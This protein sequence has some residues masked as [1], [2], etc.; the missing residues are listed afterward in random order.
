MARIMIV[1]D[2]E[3]NAR[4]I[5]RVLSHMGGHEVSVTEDAEEVLEACTGGCVDLVV[6]DVSLCNT[7]YLGKTVDGLALTRLIR[8]LV[9]APSPP[10]LLLTAHAM[11]GDRERL[12]QASGA[13]GYLAKPIVDHNELVAE[14]ARLVGTATAAIGNG[15]WAM[16]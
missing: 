12:L 13:D 1:E 8:E 14:A 6:M 11:R 10:V 2:D 16:V 4:V 9:P 5:G 7:R 15:E 3:T